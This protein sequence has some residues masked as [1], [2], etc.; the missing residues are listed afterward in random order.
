[1][2]NISLIQCSN[3]RLSRAKSRDIEFCAGVSRL[4]S[5][6]TGRAALFVTSLLAATPALAEPAPDATTLPGDAI[7]VTATRNPTETDK[8]ASSITVLTKEAIDQA[9]DIGLTELLARTPGISFTRNG[10]YG[11]APQLR[12]RGAETDHTVV[13]IDGV[14]LNDP[15]STGG[16]YNFANLLVGDI[17][18]IEIVRGPQ[19]ILW[20]SQAIGGVVNIVT[21]SPRSDLEASA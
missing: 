1:M 7:I 4:R 15:S 12:I 11:T 17:D 3:A 10:G 14:K 18:R 5:T 20:G 19:S 9:Q 2:L 21:A 16:G 8:I 6:R 13:V